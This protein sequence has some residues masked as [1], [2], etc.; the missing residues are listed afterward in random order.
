MSEAKTSS[1]GSFNINACSQCLQLLFHSTES[2]VRHAVPCGHVFC[3]GCLGRV[4][5]EQK[6]GASVC[7]IP[8]CRKTL[9]PSAE[10]TVAS[11]V[12]RTSR[13]KAELAALLG[14]Q[15][16][17]GECPNARSTSESAPA[18]GLCVQHRL[19]LQAVE[20][21]TYRPVCSECLT[22]TEAKVDVKTFD[23]ANTILESLH[24]ATSAEAA[25]HIAALA[26]PTFTPEDF[27][28]RIS[29]WGAEESARIRAWEEREVKRVQAVA[30]ENV[31]LVQEVCARRIE[32]G[33]SVFT[34]RMCLRASLEEF[35]QALADLSVTLPSD[36]AAR[37]SK[38]RAICTER[39]RLCELL[40]G[41][42]I[43]VPSAQAILQWA[44][45]PVLSGVF[46][47]KAVGDLASAITA[48]AK[49]TLTWAR[50]RIPWVLSR[51]FPVLPN[52]VG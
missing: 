35:E 45:L 18:S 21:S 15:G 10:F 52:V 44:E 5:E 49:A 8:G 16:N 27:C 50:S 31:Q 34:Q 20:V 30:A 17:A 40:A 42:K 32:V 7:R 3:K 2:D 14:D 46:D 43:A 19:P 41:G 29:K 1:E 26:E 6:L 4:D 36:P 51:E 12:Q 39:M 13:V 28:D 24:A 33:A 47:E 38:K 11:C 48:K 23:E 9:G 22:T 37:L 25:K